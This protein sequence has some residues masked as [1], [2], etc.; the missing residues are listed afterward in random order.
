MAPY[1]LTRPKALSITIAV[2][3]AIVLSFFALETRAHAEDASSSTPLRDKIQN[4]LDERQGAIQQN[5]DEK[6]AEIASSTDNSRADIE[7]HKSSMAKKLQ[8]RVYSL[9][10]NVKGRMDA[11]I[12]RL[13]NIAGRIDS[14]TDTV[15]ASGVDG[16]K[17]KELTAKARASLDAARAILAE[18]PG[19]FVYQDRPFER[20]MAVRDNLRTAGSD[21]RDARTALIDA[22]AELKSEIAA[23][24]GQGG[25][26]DAV[27]Q[28]AEHS[29]STASSTKH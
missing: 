7:A 10:H 4:R 12:F 14:R 19:L 26:S 8:E 18:D 28:N 24:N 21:I 23:A 5:I 9:M 29:S 13:D 3:G 15:K 2:C 25:V 6:R 1:T 16:T 22:F 17:V 27:R 11:A 20:F